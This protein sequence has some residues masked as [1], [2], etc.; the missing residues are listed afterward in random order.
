MARS[1][2]IHTDH[3]WCESYDVLLR[4]TRDALPEVAT[5]WI[6]NR[7]LDDDICQNVLDFTPGHFTRAQP[8]DELHNEFMDFAMKSLAVHLLYILA[9]LPQFH[10]VELLSTVHQAQQQ[11]SESTRA[12][13]QI[14][15]SG[16]AVQRFTKIYPLPTHVQQKKLQGDCTV[17]GH[18][19]FVQSSGCCLRHCSL[20]MI[21]FHAPYGSGNVTKHHALI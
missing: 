9:L 14:S 19:C 6:A 13:D 8:R 10:I 7:K 2:H 1:R 21:N 12:V 4:E 5:S 15:V 16:K 18:R 20:L 17:F 11:S 3:M